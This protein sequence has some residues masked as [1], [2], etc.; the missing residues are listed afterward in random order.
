MSALDQEAGRAETRGKILQALRSLLIPA[1]G[2]FIIGG[3]WI[4]KSESP[5]STQQ[6]AVSGLVFLSEFAPARSGVDELL[7]WAKTWIN[8]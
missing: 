4:W 3:L 1:F 2:L 6:S 7:E 8:H 5:N